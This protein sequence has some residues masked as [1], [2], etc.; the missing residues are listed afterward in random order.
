MKLTFQQVTR[1][2]KQHWNIRRPSNW[3]QDQLYTVGKLQEW[4]KEGWCLSLNAELTVDEVRQVVAKF[5]RRSCSTE[6]A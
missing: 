5:G 4:R 2:G 1:K 6:H 3:T